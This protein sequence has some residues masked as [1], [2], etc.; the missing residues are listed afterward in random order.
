MGPP[1]PDPTC[2][3]LYGAPN[4]NTGLDAETCIGTIPG[5]AGTWTPPAWAA[6]D[7]DGLGAWTLL[8][9]PTPPAEDP[10]LEAAPTRD[11]NAV[12]GVLPEGEGPGAYRL[13]TYTDPS[14]AAAAGAWVTHGGACGLCSSLEDLAVYAGI[15]D[16]TQPV[17]ACGLEGFFGAFEDTVSCLE[18]LGFTP[19]CA[20]I[21]A[22]NAQH[23]QQECQDTCLALLDAPSHVRRRPQRLPPV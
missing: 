6:A 12:C 8:D 3:G 23:T 9:P 15:S 14:A 19:P 4:E 21:W 5:D 20:R 2:V 17:R 16:L 22:Y 13:E 1:A 18:G 7:V 10:Y 11:P